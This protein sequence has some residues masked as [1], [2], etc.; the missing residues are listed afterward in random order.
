MY[1]Q[2]VAPTALFMSPHGYSLGPRQQFHSEGR[3]A[4]FIVV[5]SQKINHEGLI[6]YFTH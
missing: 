4:A 3:K 5:C 6:F 1:Q 2:L